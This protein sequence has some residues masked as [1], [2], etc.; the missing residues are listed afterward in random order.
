MVQLL[1]NTALQGVK[2]NIS[3]YTL[4]QQIDRQIHSRTCQ[5]YAWRTINLGTILKSKITIISFQKYF[6]FLMKKCNFFLGP[7]YR[8]QSLG[9]HYR[10]QSFNISNYEFCQLNM[11]KLEISKVLKI[12]YQRYKRIDSIYN[13]KLIKQECKYFL[14]LQLRY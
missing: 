14:N 9:P 13:K 8:T 10:T 12:N 3:R 4:A 11:P 1:S 2:R 5:G 6:A 7:H